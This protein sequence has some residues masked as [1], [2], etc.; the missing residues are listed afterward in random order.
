MTVGGATRTLAE[1]IKLAREDST[2][3]TS[4]LAPRFL[5]GS[6]ILF[7]QF[8]RLVQARLLDKPEAFITAQ[9]EAM[10]QRHTR[11]GDSL[12]LL[13]PNV[14]EGAGGLRDYHAAYWAMQAAVPGAPVS[15]TSCTRAC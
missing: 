4:L 14:K 15:A 3:C 11:Y 2:V 7:H 6:G 12:Y 9:I 13:Q 1:T 8:T 5:A 10:H